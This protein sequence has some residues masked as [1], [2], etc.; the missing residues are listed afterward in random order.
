MSA[1]NLTSE[2]LRR[3][4]E[5]KRKA[6][7]KLAQKNKQPHSGPPVDQQPTSVSNIPG[8]QNSVKSVI[9]P[10]SKPIAH[11]PYNVKAVIN[12]SETSKSNEPVNVADSFQ[13]VT[14]KSET[15]K[16]SVNVADSFKAVTFNSETSKTR[17]IVANS[18]KSVTNDSETLNRVSVLCRYKNEN[19]SNKN[20]NGDTNNTHVL[21]DNNS[22]SSAERIEQN[23][24]KA[25][26]KRAEKHKSPIK[27][28]SNV[29]TNSTN[30]MGQ[31][32]INTRDKGGQVT[33]PQNSFTS[34]NKI[35]SAGS[36]LLETNQASA[37]SHLV[38]NQAS[39][40]SQ[41]LVT[42][43]ASAGSNLIVTNQETK[44]S[45]NVTSFQKGVNVFSAWERSDSQ[46]RTTENVLPAATCSSD[47]TLK[48]PSFFGAPSK[49]EC[50]LVSRDRFTV[51]IGYCAPL[52]EL[53][54]TMNT[55]LYDAPAK[56]WTISLSE[57]NKF[58]TSC[59]SLKPA[60]TVEPLP[61]ALLTAFAVQI[62]GGNP[63]RDIPIADLSSVE[64]SL[65]SSLMS[66]QRKGVDFGVSKNGRVLIADDM[67]LGKTIQAICLA[68]YYKDEWPLL[69]VVPSSVRFDWS[70][71]FQRWVP[72]LDPQSVNVVVAGKDSC[73]SGLINILSY[74]L[75][76]RQAEALMKKRFQVIIMDEC[77]LLKNYK[78]ARCKAAMPLLQ[79]ARRV[80]L[81]S[82]TPALSRPSELYTQINAVCPYLFKYHDFGVRYCDG[83]QERWGWDYTGSSNM[84]ELQILLEERVMIRRLKKDVLTELPDK[85]RKMILLDPGSIKVSREL[86]SASKV[87]TSANLKK[88]DEQGAL[89]DFFHKSGFAKM[90]AIKNYVEELLE[91]ENKFLIFGHHGDI[92]DGIE[93][94]VKAKIG[95]QYIRID[96]KTSSEQRNVFC[97]KFQ[98]RD[99]IRVAILSITACNAGLNLSAANLVVFAELF[100]NP[101][102]LVQA[103]DR[104]H[105][106][107][108]QDSVVVQYLVATGTSD[109]HI[110]TSVRW[111][112]A[113]FLTSHST[114]TRAAC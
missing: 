29:L 41:L 5:N 52:I 31:C 63:S 34:Y 24:L 95:T 22:L 101:G 42:N 38:T 27:Q 54:K 10:P 114:L 83:R 2:Q 21:A 85:I 71:Q 23:R 46:L 58:M 93:E 75:M 43:Q 113:S 20:I 97:Q 72:S 6:L 99:D 32:I 12:I 33:H 68:R 70:Q 47:Q 11:V 78:T 108:Q 100:W 55:K 44:T 37:G 111:R 25:L 92:L 86:R 15:S 9:K 96:G 39:A 76:A 87:M 102:I 59:M 50:I 7:A 57:Y 67:G 82:G 28:A 53:F 77:H 94:I 48:R 69:V 88:K 91:G 3:I 45:T 40:G 106:I 90:K 14:F 109:D 1:S 64:Q 4:E 17:V 79:T 81:L 98:L 56:Q 13:A 16:S 84:G 61:K 112:S 66:F 65:V 104:A 110:W 36:N 19:L 35:P 60:V 51:K 74:D 26:A 8:P 89:L 18:F 30:S 105:R 62:K 80:I 49:G 107:G 73:T 103:E